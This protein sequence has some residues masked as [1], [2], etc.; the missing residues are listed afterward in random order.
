IEEG[1]HVVPPGSFP[2]FPSLSLLPPSF[3]LFFP[4]FPLFSLSPLLSPLFFS[5]F[6]SSFLSSFFP[7]FPFPPLSFFLPFFSSFSLPFLSSF[8]LSSFPF[9]S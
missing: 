7:L 8:F 5:S 3:L 4:F 2:P 9:S 6:L 1:V